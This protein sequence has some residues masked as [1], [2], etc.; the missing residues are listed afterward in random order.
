MYGEFLTDSKVQM[1]SEADQR[2]FIMVLCIRSSN[3]D[4]TLQDADVAFQL[5]ISDEEWTATKARFIA[6][7]LIGE[8][9]HPVKWGKRQYVSDRSN[10]RVIRHRQKLKQA[11]SDDVTLQ[12]RPQIQNPDTERDRIPSTELEPANV[13][14]SEIEKLVRIGIGSERHG[15]VSPEA[16]L[17]VCQTL[18]IATADPLEEAFERVRG[19]RPA[20]TSIDRWFCDMAPSLWKNHPE[21]H[22]ACQPVATGPD[23]P[24][25]PIV[26]AKPS[27]SLAKSALVKAAR[28]AN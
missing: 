11:G 22:A 24:S 20:R 16:K 5:R 19:N 7:N 21:L 10:E 15:T 25:Q 26:P 18:A 2:R 12:K 3:G 28:H 17:R 6:R 1:L 27:S 14:K 4:V 8:D 13:K 23:P 9:N